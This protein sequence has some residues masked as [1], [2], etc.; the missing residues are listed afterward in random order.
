MSVNGSGTTES[1]G[2]I[3]GGGPTEGGG[4]TRGCGERHPLVCGDHCLHLT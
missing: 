1:G 3:K 4:T 2:T